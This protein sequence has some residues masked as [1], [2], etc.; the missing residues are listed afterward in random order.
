MSFYTVSDT[1]LITNGGSTVIS[2][3]GGMDKYDLVVSHYVSDTNKV[4][5]KLY[6]PGASITLSGIT[7]NIKVIQ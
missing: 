7:A 2:F 3:T 1:S 4:T 6:N 5:L